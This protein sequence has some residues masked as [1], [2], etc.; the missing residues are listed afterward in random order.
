MQSNKITGVGI[1]KRLQQ[2]ELSF[3]ILLQLFCNWR[4]CKKKFKVG[5]LRSSSRSSKW[6]RD[7]KMNFWLYTCNIGLRHMWMRQ[8]SASALVFFSGFL[9]AAVV[10]NAGTQTG[11]LQAT[12]T[13]CCCWEAER[14]ALPAP[15]SWLRR[16]WSTGAPAAWPWSTFFQDKAGNEATFTCFSHKNDVE[17]IRNF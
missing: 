17:I 10:A 11:A 16:E 15:S 6:S 9:L 5:Q 14:A 8:V 3:K 7:Y 2:L 4:Q 13:R 1:K 12:F